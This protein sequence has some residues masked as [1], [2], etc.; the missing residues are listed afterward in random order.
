MVRQL[1]KIVA[2]PNKKE[3]N[4]DDYSGELRC[5][6]W[7]KQVRW[8][9]SREGGKINKNRSKSDGGN[10]SK[11]IEQRKE[12]S[13]SGKANENTKPATKIPQPQS[14]PHTESFSS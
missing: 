8:Q 1:R 13:D 7:K 5:S 14:I 2:C 3:H 6:M 11:M 12:R 10:E 9:K 4:T